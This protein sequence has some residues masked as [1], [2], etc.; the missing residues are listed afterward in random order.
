MPD[1]F[2]RR[3][4]LGRHDEENG[5]MADRLQQLEQKNQALEETIKQMQGKIFSPHVTSQP[6]ISTIRRG[7]EPKDE[8]QLT[9]A[10]CKQ[11]FV[12]WQ[13]PN[14]S[15]RNIPDCDLTKEGI[16]PTAVSDNWY[17]Y[18]SCTM[19]CASQLEAAV[20]RHKGNRIEVTPLFSDIPPYRRGH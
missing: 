17:S 5:D 2:G 6:F 15:I 14:A 19:Q 11:E 7:E 13:R 18:I 1:M 9:C 4:I 16:R 3:R 10:V 20:G 12:R 8:R